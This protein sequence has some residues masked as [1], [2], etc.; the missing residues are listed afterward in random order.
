MENFTFSAEAWTA[1]GTWATFLVLG[2]T[3]YF[4]YQQVAEASKLRREQTRP[5]VV[6]S[7]DIEQRMLF[8]LTVENIGSSPA[9]DVVIDFDQELRSSLKE[10]ENVRMFKEPIPML[11]PGR[12]FRAT[13]E[14]SIDVFGEDYSHPLSYRANATYNDHRG[15]RYGPEHYVLDFRMYEGQAV[16][17]KGLNELVGL[18]EDLVKEHKKWTD[19]VK[20]LRVHAVDAIRKDRRDHRPSRIRQMKRAF[21]DKGI[22]GAASYWIEVW[23]RRY[24][25][26]SR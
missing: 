14:S 22:W 21:R 6:V 5:Y 10:I 2:I 7:I 18:L 25:L 1:A 15:H 13:W 24:G 9:F 23:I 16:G 12:K 3:L 11:P 8:M 19:G 20:G 17:P 4:V 26:W